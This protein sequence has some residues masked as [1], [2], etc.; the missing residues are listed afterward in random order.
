MPDQL[1]KKIPDD[2]LGMIA[3]CEAANQEVHSVADDAVVLARVT[4]ALSLQA[5]VDTIASK[6]ASVRL[7]RAITDKLF[8]ATSDRTGLRFCNEAIVA[9]IVQAGQNVPEPDC[10]QPL[11]TF[12]SHVFDTEF[13]TKKPEAAHAEADYESPKVSFLRQFVAFAAHEGF[14]PQE[15][16]AL[17]ED[18]LQ[19][20]CVRENTPFLKLSEAR[21]R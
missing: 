10:M 19:K 12:A 17:R 6:G 7:I 11:V 18:A 4:A 2:V 14:T 8:H 9:S 3:E 16:K 21:E 13:G 15:M 5:A 20:F 1:M